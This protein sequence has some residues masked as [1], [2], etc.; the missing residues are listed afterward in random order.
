MVVIRRGSIGDGRKRGMVCCR[1][2]DVAE[3]RIQDCHG[4]VEG[5]R[6]LCACYACHEHLRLSLLYRISMCAIQLRRSVM[7]H[8]GRGIRGFE[9]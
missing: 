2:D 8:S 9:Q 5:L 7:E 6:C 1:H 3:S 4:R